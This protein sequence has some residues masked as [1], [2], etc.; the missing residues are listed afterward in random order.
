MPDEIDNTGLVLNTKERIAHRVFY[1]NGHRFSAEQCNLDQIKDAEFK[2]LPERYGINITLED[3][4]LPE[5][6][7]WCEHCGPEL[8]NEAG[9]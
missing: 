1:D 2:M 7:R 5:G 6:Y 9:L 8:F 4:D 3:Q